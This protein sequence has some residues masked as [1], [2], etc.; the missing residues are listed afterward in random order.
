[1]VVIGIAELVGLFRA[2]GAGPEDLDI[3]D[4]DERREAAVGQGGIEEGLLGAVDVEIVHA[5][6]CET[7]LA[8]DTVRIT[9]LGCQRKFAAGVADD[10][11]GAEPGLDD[12]G[13]DAPFARSC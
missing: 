8:I 1:M 5:L 3:V 6:L 11:G 12:G 4:A 13:G 2:I 7:E 10:A 9:G